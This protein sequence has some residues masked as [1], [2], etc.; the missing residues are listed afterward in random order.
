MQTQTGRPMIELKNVVKTFCTKDGS[1]VTAVNGVNLTIGRGEIYGIIGM[2]GAGKTTLVRCMNLL[3]RP[4]SGSVIIDGQDLMALSDKELSQMRREVGMVFQSFNLLMQ[5][6]VLKNICLPLE[7]AGV[8]KKDAIRRAEELLEIVGLSE[9][10]KNYPVQLSGG[11][12][13]RIAI[14][15]ALASNPKVLL[16]DEATSALDPM[17]TR[18]ILELLKDINQRMGITIVVI[19]HEMDVIREIC[20]RVAVMDGSVIVEEGTVEEIFARPKTKAAL[21][22]F[23]S[24]DS[25]I[26]AANGRTYRVVFDGNAAYEPV[27]AGM[28]MAC[29]APVNILYGSIERV[30][31][32]S[33]GQLVIQLPEEE[34]IQRQA[35]DYLRVNGLSYEEVENE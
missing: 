28:V 1:E 7:I 32:K 3:E 13:Q 27:I 31:Q 2:S 33:F 8:P 22:L 26:P 30:N 35:L 24:T 25:E 20:T 34:R 19:T 5:D 14:A 21:R 9:K 11:Q 23:Y 6:T 18:S 16:C 10:A 12:K 15:R 17:T 4:T 29:N